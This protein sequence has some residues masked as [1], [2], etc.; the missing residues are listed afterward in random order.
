V[1]PR[2]AAFV[3]FSPPRLTSVY[4]RERLFAELD[5]LRQHSAL[6]IAAPGGCGKTTLV[7]SYLET[8][9]LPC[10]WYQVDAGDADP[11]SFFHHLELAIRTATPRFR[12]PLPEL[13]PEHLTDIGAFAR[14]L[15]REIARRLQPSTMLVFDNVQ[16][17]GQAPAFLDALRTGIEQLPRNIHV[18]FISR[19]DPPAAFARMRVNRTLAF[20]SWND[21]KLRQ[22]ESAALAGWLTRDNTR[23]AA[24]ET[25]RLHSECDGWIAGLILLLEGA[26]AR[27]NIDAKVDPLSA[28]PLF[29][30]FAAEVFAH[31]PAVVQQFLMLTALFPG[32]TAE[33]AQ[34]LTGEA[35]ARALLDDLVRHH[36]FTEWHVEPQPA[37]QYHPLFRQFLRDRAHR[38]WSATE[39]RDHI[40]TAARIL[41]ESGQ[42]DH[43]QALY[44][45][46]GDAE[47][48]ARVI[49]MRA[50]RLAATGRVDTLQGAI[51]A[52]P[53]T[54]IDTQPWLRYWLAVCRTATDLPA[55]RACFEQAYRAFRAVGDARGSYLAWAGV[56]ES[57]VFLWGEFNELPAWIDELDAL[58]H[59]IP[60][61]PDRAVEERVTYAIL[62]AHV[63]AAPEW[64]AIEPW[65]TR[66][67]H[68]A[69]EGEDPSIRMMTVA[70]LGLYLPWLGEM[71]RYERVVQAAR[72]LARSESATPFAR[73]NLLSME[74]RSR[75][76]YGEP[77]QARAL[78]REAAAFASAS[79]VR[80]LDRPIQASLAGA[81]AH[82]GDIVEAQA[83][84]ERYR[85]L[86]APGM[87]LEEAHWFYLASFVDTLR[88][89]LHRAHERGRHAF[90]LA[91]QCRVP[92]AEIVC[93]LSYARVLAQ[94]GRLGDAR[95]LVSSIEPLARA[96]RSHLFESECC[97]MR[98]WFAR[99]AGELA[100]CLTNLR[101]AF[102][103]MQEHGFR[104]YVAWNPEWL[105]ELCAI[106]LEHEIEVPTV[107]SLVRAGRLVPTAQ[108]STP[109][110]W[111]WPVRIRTLGG[112]ELQVRD[113]RVRFGT[114]TQK[115]PLELLHALLALGGRAVP[116]EQ[117]TERLWPD[118]DGDAAHRVFDTTLHRLRRL[119]DAE[120]AVVVEGGCVTLDPRYVWVDA[121]AFE[122]D[123]VRAEREPEMLERALALY[124]GAFLDRDATSWILP[125]RERL[126]S[127]FM[128]AVEHLGN[129]HED[130]GR[131]AA[132]IECYRRGI[133]ADPL[134]EAVY[135]RLMLCFERMRRHAEALATF[136]RLR[137]MLRS[138]LGIE[139]SAPSRELH[140]RLR[141]A[142]A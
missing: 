87:H 17:A 14:N 130:R 4:P 24:I 133:E 16:D 28:Q 20:L 11:Q 78:A 92:F 119:L 121:W 105:A 101:S 89:D 73:L 138:Q 110:N 15:F 111:P 131:V 141:R 54:L 68:L 74:S 137:T 55:A 57:Y 88:G 83:A 70:S 79:G 104:S 67:E 18:V 49:L 114:K 13:R 51:A 44:L 142:M 19:S 124:R 127:M 100:L 61:F 30:Y 42:A 21:L 72:D 60:Q 10:V 5:E 33:M 115:K 136:E 31:R 112:F 65:A 128:R 45:E 126:R 53:S 38:A 64:D 98:A 82:V 90:Q 6:W 84:L 140:Q 34:R 41:E 106:A 29:D 25:E 103:L 36:L 80:A 102:A 35:R 39:L 129:L 97:L 86:L 85:A 118:S 117:L 47:S 32:F 3:K 122:R 62:T 135:Y 125:M 37:Y 9:G 71:G 26:R 22:E 113:A 56:V 75:Q 132:A 123:V 139:P 69:R 43:A 96:M 46:A 52:L 107:Q 40:Q 50:P 134:A 2:N 59:E 81:N 120:Q 48:A 8:R 95:D 109:E 93:G 63:F 12:R 23:G 116:E 58:R 77:Q 7:A 99:R 94:S 91:R 27:G 1:T 76:L 66:A 108:T